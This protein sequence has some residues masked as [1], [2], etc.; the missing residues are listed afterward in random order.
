MA[1]EPLLEIEVVYARPEEQA[2]VA[3]SVPAGTTAAEAAR[4]SGLTERFPEIA[5]GAKL[6]V[7]GKVVAPDTPLAAGD[8]VEIYRPLVA[9]PK[10][11]RRGR[12]GGAM[13]VRR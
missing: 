10:Q 7:F 3:L 1:A 12:A 11:A 4:R 8:R 9:D 2:V 6:G 13:R 5:A